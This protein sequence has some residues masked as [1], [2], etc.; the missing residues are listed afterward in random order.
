MRIAN[1]IES[2]LIFQILFF[3]FSI[4]SDANWIEP[5]QEIKSSAFTKNTESISGNTN[6][7]CDSLPAG[8]SKDWL[9]SLLDENGNPVIPEDPEGD[10]LQQSTFNGTTSGEKFGYSV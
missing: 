3:S 10:A 4:S 8:V 6:I 1:A 2:C 7:K 5:E 9:N